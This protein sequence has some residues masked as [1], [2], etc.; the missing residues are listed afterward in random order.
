[1]SALPVVDLAPEWGQASRNEN[2]NHYDFHIFVS[3]NM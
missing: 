1:M 2:Q 3:L